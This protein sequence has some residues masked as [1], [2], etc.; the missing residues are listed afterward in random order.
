[1]EDPV[2]LVDLII[3]VGGIAL[4]LLTSVRV[5][6]RRS[7]GKAVK[8]QTAAFVGIMVWLGCFGIALYLI[9]G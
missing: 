7:S 8:G 3:L 4:I 5:S 2:A 6:R 9:F 1:M